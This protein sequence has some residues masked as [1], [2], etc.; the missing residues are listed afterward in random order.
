[1]TILD[2]IC[3]QNF[4]KQSPAQTAPIPWSQLQIKDKFILLFMDFNILHEILQYA[5][6][7]QLLTK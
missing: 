6:L 7:I 5:Q 2:V 1:M 4:R 3:T